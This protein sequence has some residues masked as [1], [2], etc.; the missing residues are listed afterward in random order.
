MVSP[1]ALWTR[2]R[3]AED[4]E[5]R[6]R[7]RASHR[8]YWAAHKDELNARRRE[9]RRTDPEYR[10][11]LRVNRTRRYG[12]SGDDYYTLLKRQGG[13][14]AI[15]KKKP[16]R[17][18]LAV[19]HCHSTHWVRGLLCSKC[20][21]GLGQFDDDVPRMLA[22]IA[23]LMASR[24]D[25]VKSAES[26]ATASKIAERLRRVLERALRAHFQLRRGSKRL[27]RAS[28]PTSRSS[29]SGSPPRGSSRRPVRRK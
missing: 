7:K 9:R 13:A 12:I 21:T 10:E 23:Y 28:R 1:Q 11:Q 17:R 3:Y 27:L 22:A 14:C 19:D 2:K 4:P 29:G 25:L 6:E 18:R 5:F 26:R 16:G 8:R 20:N 24:R 15:C